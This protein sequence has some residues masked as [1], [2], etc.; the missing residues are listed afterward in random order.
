[1]YRHMN[2][3]IDQCN[4]I[5]SPEINP[6]LY[7]QLI[8]NKG[9]RSIKW[10]KNLMEFNKWCWG[11]WTAT[12]KKMKLDHQIILYIKIRWIKKLNIRCDTIKVLKES[13]GRKISDIPHSDIFTDMFPRPRDIEE[14]INKWD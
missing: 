3:H 9:G 5:E 8:F 2:R 7:N 4:R 1:M 10:S 12:C 13:I 6:C 11:T 14:R